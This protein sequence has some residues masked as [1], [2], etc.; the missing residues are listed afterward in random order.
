MPRSTDGDAVGLQ[1]WINLS[2]KDKMIKPRYQDVSA[3]QIPIV[4]VPGVRLRVVSGVVNGE[5]G[6][7]KRH[8]GTPGLL[9]DVDIGAGATW[10]YPV[11][12]DWNVF[13]YLYCGS[14]EIG[15]KSVVPRFAYVLSNDG[16]QMTTTAG[17]KGLKCIVAA[18]EPLK[19]P[20]VQ[21]EDFDFDEA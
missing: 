5:V 14:G 7:L 10:N 15:S 18:S 9:L 17:N 3:E 1:L 4:N 21:R 16:D 11:N 6:P 2:A 13:I 20:I 12:A 19:E 8:P